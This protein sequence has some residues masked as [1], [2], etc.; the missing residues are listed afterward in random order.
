MNTGAII[1]V[2]LMLGSSVALADS[3]SVTYKKEKD[4]FYIVSDKKHVLSIDYVESDLLKDST[5]N[6]GNFPQTYIEVFK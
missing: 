2:L 3:K 6:V 5:K 4:Q 1:T